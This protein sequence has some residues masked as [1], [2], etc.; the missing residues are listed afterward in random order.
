ME[1]AIE[2]IKNVDVLILIIGV[3]SILLGIAGGIKV[4][5]NSIDLP[6]RYQRISVVILG[7][8]LLI[9]GIFPILMPNGW[10]IDIKEMLLEDDGKFEW[11]WAGQ[12]WLGQAVFR[13]TKDDKLEVVV[14]VDKV[15][16]IQGG[17]G[18]EEETKIIRG[19]W[20]IRT[21]IEDEGEVVIHDD[22]IELRDLFCEKNAFGF[23]E[24]ENGRNIEGMN[25]KET[26][27]V[28]LNASKLKLVPAFAGKLEYYNKDHKIKSTGD[29]IL[30]KYR[31]GLIFN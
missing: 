30:V 29:I 5:G 28:V 31:P 6:K 19:P 20:V 13:E 2:L 25:I 18:G 4:K 1:F 3:L 7:L 11:Q 27:I 24:A 12:N 9:V 14:K 23:I 8:V 17:K 16:K 26:N 22:Y 15:Y 10:G 21:P